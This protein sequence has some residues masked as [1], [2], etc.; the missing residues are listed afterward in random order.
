MEIYF[1]FP[2]RIKKNNETKK[3]KTETENLKQL[4]IVTFYFLPTRNSLLTIDLLPRTG[5]GVCI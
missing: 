4:Q 1:P 2:I 3:S 5:N